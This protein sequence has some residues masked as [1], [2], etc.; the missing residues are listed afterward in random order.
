MKKALF[1]V[2]MVAVAGFAFANGQGEEG[3][4]AMTSPTQ[5]VIGGPADV[6][7]AAG[8]D[9]GWIIIFEGDVTVDSEVTVS[10]EVYEEPGAEAPRRKLALYTQDADRNIIDRFTLTVPRLVIEHVNTRIQGGIVKGDVYV[11]AEGFQMRDATIDGNLYFASQALQDASEID[12]NS[13]VTGEIA[14]QSM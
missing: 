14:V 6:Q 4:D 3:T 1:F 2:L 10:G 8:P 11:D 13:T 9:G 5:S 12:E 7:P